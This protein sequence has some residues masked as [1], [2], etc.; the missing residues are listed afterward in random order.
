MKRS[1]STLDNTE[2]FHD[3]VNTTSRKRQQQQP[4]QLMSTSYGAD[5]TQNKEGEAIIVKED[6]PDK[7]V[8]STGTEA[9]EEEPVRV[10]NP[11]IVRC[12]KAKL[13]DALDDMVC[14]IVKNLETNGDVS[15][16]NKIEDDVALGFDLKRHT[17]EHNR[18]EGNCFTLKVN[19]SEGSAIGKHFKNSYV[20]NRIALNCTGEENCKQVIIT[21]KSN[22]NGAVLDYNADLSIFHDLLFAPYPSSFASMKEMKE[23]FEK[24]WEDN[25]CDDWIRIA[26]VTCP[27]SSWTIDFFSSAFSML[28]GD[29]Y[30]TWCSD[31]ENAA[32]V[33]DNFST[34]K[35]LSSCLS[36]HS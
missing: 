7:L 15:H 16:L 6:A 14:K 5:I 32:L 27:G 22:A 13:T 25:Q 31:K 26:C 17:F 8:I 24:I 1:L 36:V 2:S 35:A 12:I 3:N 34:P 10:M 19:Y 30:K 9:N 28:L 23:T 29:S 11:C 33:A 20:L 21:I 4:K 18:E